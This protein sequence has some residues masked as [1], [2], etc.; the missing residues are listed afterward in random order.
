[1]SGVLSVRV[2]C[3]QAQSRSCHVLV[4]VVPQINC[5]VLVSLVPRSTV[6]YLCLECPEQ[7]ACG[8]PMAPTQPP[9]S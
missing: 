6:M 1:M 9:Y 4:S 5:H 7:L 8:A 3:K 2:G